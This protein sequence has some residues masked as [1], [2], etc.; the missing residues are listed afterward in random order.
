MGIVAGGMQDGSV[1]IWDVNSIVKNKSE[2]LGFGCVS[3]ENVHDGFSVNTIEFNPIKPTLLASGGKEVFIQD[4]SKSV[5]NPTV[6][7]PGEPNY[8][9]G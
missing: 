5:S 2:K 6:F 1:T 4:L 3:S 7:T 9:E 8:H